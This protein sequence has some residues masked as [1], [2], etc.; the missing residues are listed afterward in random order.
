MSDELIPHEDP[1][2][3]EHCDEVE[4][5]EISSEEVDVVVAALE[6]LIESVSSENIKSLL[7]ETSNSVFYLVYDE[8]D[9]EDS[10]DENDEVDQVDAQAA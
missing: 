6:S 5:E 3:E 2:A 9:L 7:E 4:F 8:S 1:L 10:E